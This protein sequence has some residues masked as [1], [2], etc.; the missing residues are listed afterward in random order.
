MKNSLFYFIERTDSTNNYLKREIQKRELIHEKVEEFSCIYTD[1]QT[2]GRGLDVN[3]WES[4]K[5][6]NLLVSFYFRPPLPVAKQFIFNQFFSLSIKKLLQHYIPDIKIKWSNDIY[7]QN[8]KIAG[9]LIE[10]FIEGDKISKTVAGV[11]INI[12][13]TLFSSSLPNPTSLKI[14]TGKEYKIATILDQFYAILKA[15][16]RML[17]LGKFAYFQENYIKS[18]YLFNKKAKYLISGEEKVCVIKGLDQFGQLILE[19]NEGK[20]KSYGYK[21]VKFL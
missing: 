16:Y 18:M 4:K 15:D 14:L 20:I 12:N 9:I 6:E 1:E 3:Q 13:Q 21:E 10:H 19:D 17:K 8:C 7:V 2:Q 5:G 11:G